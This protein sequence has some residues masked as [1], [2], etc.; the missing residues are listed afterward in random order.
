MAEMRFLKRDSRGWA[1]AWATVCAKYG[2][3]ECYD[4]RSGESWQYMGTVVKDD[5]R[6][7]HQFRHRSLPATGEREYFAVR[8]D[9]DPDDYT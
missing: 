9:L 5:G 2:D 6:V 4:A 1:S 7:E 8:G 3:A